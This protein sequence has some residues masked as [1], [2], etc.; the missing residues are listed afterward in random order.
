MQGVLPW[1]ESL[2]RFSGSGSARVATSRSLVAGR[3]FT[4]VSNRGLSIRCIAGCLWITDG[5]SGDTLLRPGEK[6]LA[7]A[8]RRVVIEAIGDSVMETGR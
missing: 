5:R 3:V 2:R 4:V 7:V 8:G 1:F 6:F